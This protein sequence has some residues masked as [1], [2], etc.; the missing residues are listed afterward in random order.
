MHTT[1]ERQAI[2]DRIARNAALCQRVHKDAVRDHDRARGFVGILSNITG[3][4]VR[5]DG[6]ADN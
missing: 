6:H 4:R 1:D 3:Q 5:V 2:L